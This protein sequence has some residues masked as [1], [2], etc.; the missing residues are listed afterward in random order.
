LPFRKNSD[1]TPLRDILL[2]IRRNVFEPERLRLASLS[3]QFNYAPSYLSIFFKKHTGESLKHY[4]D[5]YKIKLIESRLLYSQATLAMIADEFGFTDESHLTKQFKKHTGFTPG[6]FR[7]N[8]KKI[9]KV[10]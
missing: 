6:N 2:Y 7:S 5:Q 8:K 3:R 4:I 10:I 1:D 9:R